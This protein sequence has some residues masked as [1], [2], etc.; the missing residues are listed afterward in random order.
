VGSTYLCDRFQL[1]TELPLTLIATAVIFP[2]VFSISGAY[3]RREHALAE[4]GSIKAHGRAI[5]FV[6]RDWLD[7]PGDE[8]LQKSKQLL[9]DFLLACR[10]LFMKPI[11][12]MHQNEKLVYK[13]FSKLS[14]FIREELRQKGLATGEVSRCNQYLN[15]MIIA[16][17]SIKH[18]Y[19]YRTPRTLK[20]FSNFFI[21]LLPILYGPHFAQLAKESAGGLNYILP[22]LLSLILVSLDNIQNHLE[23]PFDQIGEDDIRINAEKFVSG[24]D[25]E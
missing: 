9:G 2:I 20:A 21:I 11:D 19:Q 12:Q 10:E 1:T 5:Y 15:K 25:L 7:N 4:Y 8:V 23:N 3:K 14:R 16:F 13:Q 24:L 6:T 18:I 22:V 17:E